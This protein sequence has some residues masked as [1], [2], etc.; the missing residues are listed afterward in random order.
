MFMN[1]GEERDIKRL[2]A[3]ADR[4]AKYVPRNTSRWHVIMAHIFSIF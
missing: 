1:S 2:P 3:K 4:L